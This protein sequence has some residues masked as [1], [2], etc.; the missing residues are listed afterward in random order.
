[1]LERMDRHAHPEEVKG[2]EAAI[3]LQKKPAL[4]PLRPSNDRFTKDGHQE[5]EDP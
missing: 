5:G 3:I 2:F 1:M 4:S